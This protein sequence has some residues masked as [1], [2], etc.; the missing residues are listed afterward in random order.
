MS[1]VTKLCSVEGCG[2]KAVGRGLCNNHYHR[3]WYRQ[4]LVAGSKKR[5]NDGL[6]CSI[7]GCNEPLV[8]KGWC[9]RHY[10]RWLRMGDPFSVE[11]RANRKCS[12]D[13]CNNK[14]SGR[15]YCK[16]HYE[17]FRTHGR[18][19]EKHLKPPEQSTNPQRLLR[20]CHQKELLAWRSMQKRCYNQKNTS[21]HNYG[22]R[23][24]RVCSWLRLSFEYF[25]HVVGSK[26]TPSHTLDRKNFNGNYSCG[27]CPECIANGWTMNLRWATY[28]EQNNNRRDRPGFNNY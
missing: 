10:R 25:L 4:N 8:S 18:I 12:V 14:H 6:V 19:T 27:R 20:S 22:G 16:K 21:Y 13:G 1:S 5:V 23:G 15:G 7:E 2:K 9:E 28:I 17:Q 26:P 24:V 11:K 3:W